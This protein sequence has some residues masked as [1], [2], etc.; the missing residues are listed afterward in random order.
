MRSVPLDS[1]NRANR[2][3][4]QNAE[5]RT[6]NIE[7]RTFCLLA[8][9]EETLE[10]ADPG[11]MAHLAQGF[12][13]DLADALSGDTKLPADLLKSSAVAVHEAESL[14]K[15]LPFTLR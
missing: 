11:G 12:G 5:R 15:D 7:R 4:T 3:R 9:F 6:L 13:F 8:G 2:R 10:L 1:T 14:F